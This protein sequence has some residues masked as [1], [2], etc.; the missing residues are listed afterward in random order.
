MNKLVYLALLLVLT[1][2]CT[3]DDSCAGAEPLAPVSIKFN[4]TNSNGEDLIFGKDPEYP[5]RQLKYYSLDG[6]KLSDAVFYRSVS[7]KGD[8]SL[9][10]KRNNVVISFPGNGGKDTIQ[11]F[12]IGRI[13]VGCFN[14]QQYTVYYNDNI[15]FEDIYTTESQPKTIIK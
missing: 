1:S 13:Q 6:E 9:A 15:I 14:Y 2:S 12:E 5:Y 7:N 3:K 10:M 11:F 4:I 8:T